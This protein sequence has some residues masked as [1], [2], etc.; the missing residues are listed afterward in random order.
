MTTK[1]ITRIALASLIV[2][3]LWFCAAYALIAVVIDNWQWV[4]AGQL[5]HLAVSMLITVTGSVFTMNGVIDKWRKPLPVPRM[6]TDG[7][8]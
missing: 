8:R 7:R 1:L 3:H 6:S 4:L 2:A 5:S